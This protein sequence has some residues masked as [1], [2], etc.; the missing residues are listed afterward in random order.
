MA[1]LGLRESPYFDR[2]FVSVSSRENQRTQ[3]LELLN[4]GQIMHHF[5]Y[6]HFYHNILKF[7]Q[8]ITRSKMRTLLFIFVIY[9][10]NPIY[11][12]TST[13]LPSETEKTYG[14]SLSVLLRNHVGISFFRIK[15]KMFLQFSYNKVFR[16]FECH[17]GNSLV[18]PVKKIRFSSLEFDYGYI[19]RNDN[20]KWFSF[21]PFLSS[22]V[23]FP[24]IKDDKTKLYLPSFSIGVLSQAQ[25][26]RDLQ[27]GIK[28]K[29]YYFQYE[30]TFVGFDFAYSF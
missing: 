21:I 20:V 6:S 7:S 2:F 29:S 13:V 19:F 25:L 5:I 27:F 24:V 16:D 18:R 8:Q 14:V 17:D 1:R 28:L 26:F 11:S 3:A 10:P 9:L 23:L 4:A 15:E 22:G 12:Q 30:Y